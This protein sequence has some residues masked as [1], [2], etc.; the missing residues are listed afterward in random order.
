MR[1]PIQIHGE[2]FA[3]DFSSRNVQLWRPPRNVFEWESQPPLHRSEKTV[4]Q[5]IEAIRDGETPFVAVL[6]TP[7]SS[8]L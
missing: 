1:V 4:N 5:P 6:T 8:G 3:V 2:V 7:N